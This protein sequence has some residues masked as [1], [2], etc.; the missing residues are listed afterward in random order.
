MEKERIITTITILLQ[1][2][3][4]YKKKQTTRVKAPITTKNNN[5]KPVA[6]RS[7]N[8]SKRRRHVVLP[9]NTVRA[10]VLFSFEY[11]PTTRNRSERQN[12]LR[13]TVCVKKS[14]KILANLLHLSI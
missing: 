14:T 7:V 11:H 12:D 2:L 6:L 5:K 3:N 9:S 4:Y 8:R 1:L 10:T 13:G